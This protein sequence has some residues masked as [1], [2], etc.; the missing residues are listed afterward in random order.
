M[1][2]EFGQKNK[3]VIVALL[4]DNFILRQIRE[5]NV[6]MGPLYSRHIVLL[7]SFQSHSFSFSFFWPLHRVKVS[8]RKNA[9]C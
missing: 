6:G 7:R 3:W 8:I 5:K 1:F 9:P 2:Q 4:C